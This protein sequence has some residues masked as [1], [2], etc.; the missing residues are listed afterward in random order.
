M[1]VL[2]V[3]DLLDPEQGE[4]AF[5]LVAG[6]EGAGR[7]L[8]VPVLRI[9]AGGPP[10]SPAPSG[11]GLLLPFDLLRSLE[12]SNREDRERF[13][14]ELFSRSPEYIVIAEAAGCHPPFLDACDREGVPLYLTE[15]GLHASENEILRRLREKFHGRTFVHGV[16]VEVSGIGILIS[17]ESGIGKSE[18]ALELV[19]RGHR[20]VSDDLVHVERRG[21][22][23][24]GRSPERTRYFMEIR[25]LG[26]INVKSLFG[27]A[28][29]ADETPV[30]VNVELVPWKEGTAF[31]RIESEERRRVI[32]GVAIPLVRVPVRSGGN[33]ATI[34]E[35][36]A[37]NRLLKKERERESREILQQI[38][39]SR[40][41]R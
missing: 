36:V 23:L 5:V 12:T 24:R 35:I 11:G 25:G 27:V 30:E 7:K 6:R 41:R 10:G 2:T 13:F 18:C 21:V 26:L 28:A 29:V 8:G 39:E 40:F 20:L 9:Y 34:V 14:E 15:M 1:D 37:K 17:G 22:T 38:E 4:S 3:K 33:M 32:L 31:D 16:L 19:N